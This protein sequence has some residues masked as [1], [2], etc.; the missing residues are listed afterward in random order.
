MPFHVCIWRPVSRAKSHH[1]QQQHCPHFP[2]SQHTACVSSADYGGRVRGFDLC[3]HC[4]PLGEYALETPSRRQ[5]TTPTDAGFCM[6]LDYVYA[7]RIWNSPEDYVQNTRRH[8]Y[9]LPV[10]QIT[11][12]VLLI[13]HKNLDLWLWASACV[14]LYFRVITWI[15]F[16]IGYIWHAWNS[17]TS[18]E[19]P[20]SL[21]YPRIFRWI[22]PRVYLVII[23][24]SSA[25][26]L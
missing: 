20:D 3:S 5:L 6:G 10:S 2:K 4:R 25:G 11:F 8:L 24:I 12:E 26:R 13:A 18:Q 1:G 16:I 19:L 9:P 14:R 21:I 7:G 15:S 22:L 23:L 17:R